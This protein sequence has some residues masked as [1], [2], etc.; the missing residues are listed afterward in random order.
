MDTSSLSS[1]M[2]IET[3]R[4]QVGVSVL[5]SKV[6]AMSVFIFDTRYIEL[7]VITCVAKTRQQI[8]NQFEAYKL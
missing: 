3:R 5:I 8:Q 7:F 2:Y 6:A 1:I 4:Y